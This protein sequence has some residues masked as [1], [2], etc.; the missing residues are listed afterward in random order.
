MPEASANVFGSQSIVCICDCSS[1]NVYPTCF[2]GTRSEMNLFAVPEML[3]WDESRN[4]SLI[5]TM[6]QWCMLANAC[7]H[8]LTTEPLLLLTGNCNLYAHFSTQPL[9]QPKLL[10]T[11]FGSP[12]CFSSCIQRLIQHIIISSCHKSSAERWCKKDNAQNSDF[13]TINSSSV[14]LVAD[15]LDRIIYIHPN[16]TVFG[17]A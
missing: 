4:K 9:F 2:F 1:Q 11:R 7:F 17:A 10:C 5:K 16:I 6:H 12:T 14:T 8:G 3:F 13:S 15:T